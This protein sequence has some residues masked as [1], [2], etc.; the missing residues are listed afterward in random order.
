MIEEYRKTLEA[1]HELKRRGVEKGGSL[2]RLRVIDEE[3]EE[4]T[5]VLRHLTKGESRYKWTLP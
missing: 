2:R 4:V 3:I 1:L 5:E